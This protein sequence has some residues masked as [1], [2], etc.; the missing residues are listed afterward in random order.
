MARQ[1]TLVVLLLAAERKYWAYI[2]SVAVGRIVFQSR[3]R[4]VHRLPALRLYLAGVQ[5]VSSRPY[6]LADPNKPVDQL[7]GRVRVRPGTVED[8][9]PGREPPLYMVELLDWQKYTPDGEPRHLQV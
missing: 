2:F 6:L 7:G 3:W 9:K 4:A 1:V 5:L 8:A